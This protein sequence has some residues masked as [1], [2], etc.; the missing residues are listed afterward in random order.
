M[1]FSRICV[2][3]ASFVFMH[4]A[5]MCCTALCVPNGRSCLSLASFVLMPV[6]VLRGWSCPTSEHTCHHHVIDHH[7]HHDHHDL[8]KGWNPLMVTIMTVVKMIMM[9][10]MMMKK[11]PK[12]NSSSWQSD[13]RFN[14]APL[15]LVQ[16]THEKARR[17]NGAIFPLCVSL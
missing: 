15:T 3:V 12:P 4:R 5:T 6:P 1:A 9:M 2:S 11:R 10:V 14:K 8:D 16:C 17:F 7:D 13:D